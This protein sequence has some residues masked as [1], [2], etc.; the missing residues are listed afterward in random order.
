MLFTN[1]FFDITRYDLHIME[2]NKNEINISYLLEQLIDECYPIL[3]KNSLKCKLDAPA[4][5][6]YVGDGDK[7]A[8]T[9]GN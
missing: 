9:F 6:M 3:E 5:V 7:L 8:R 4:K 1:Q 2:I